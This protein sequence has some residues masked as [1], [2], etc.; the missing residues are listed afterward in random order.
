MSD[1]LK[2]AQ[3][4]C[5]PDPAENW[6]GLT[7]RE[8][9]DNLEKL[10]QGIQGQTKEYQRLRDI[11]VESDANKETLD[12]YVSDV[13]KVKRRLGLLHDTV[14]HVEN[15]LMPS[16][17]QARRMEEFGE[18][19]KK[20]NIEIDGQSH[21][22][23]AANRDEA[24]QMVRAKLA[25]I[26]T[27][28]EEH[29]EEES[30]KGGAGT[31]PKPRG[32][33]EAKLKSKIESAKAY[34]KAHGSAVP[35]KVGTVK[36][37]EKYV[38]IDQDGRETGVPT[39]I[40]RKHPEGHPQAGE[41]KSASQRRH[42]AVQQ[43]HGLLTN[44]GEMASE[45]AKLR[46]PSRKQ[47]EDAAE[48]REEKKSKSLAG[49]IQRSIGEADSPH[50][51]DH[52]ENRVLKNYGHTL[53][54]ARYRQAARMY[55]DAVG[56]PTA[57]GEG[58]TTAE[59]TVHQFY[60]KKL[61]ALRKKSPKEYSESS[62]PLIAE[63]DELLSQIRSRLDP[64]TLNRE[65]DRLI[66]EAAQDR[67]MRAGV[68]PKILAAAEKRAKEAGKGEIVKQTEKL[69]E[70]LPSEETPEEKHAPMVEAVDKHF[71]SLA[72]HKSFTPP[73][74]AMEGETPSEVL[75]REG[76]QA[77][78]TSD[79]QER[80]EIRPW[81]RKKYS[82]LL[83]GKASEADDV[84]EDTRSDAQ[85]A[86]SK[87]EVTEIATAR[88]PV[89]S[90]RSLTSPGA[91][92]EF[93]GDDA[94]EVLGDWRAWQADNP[95]ADPKEV[96]KARKRAVNSLVRQSSFGEHGSEDRRR[97][98]GRV[99]G[100]RHLSK[101]LPTLSEKEAEDVGKLD[102]PLLSESDIQS[103]VEDYG[104]KRERGKTDTE[105]ANLGVLKQWVRGLKSTLG[106]ARKKAYNAQDIPLGES[107][108][109]EGHTV[110]KDRYK[111]TEKKLL[112][113]IISRLH[114]G[115]SEKTEGG[116]RPVTELSSG[117]RKKLMSKVG[118]TLDDKKKLKS[119][120]GGD[121]PFSVLSENGKKE[122]EELV[123]KSFDWTYGMFTKDVFPGVF[124]SLNLFKNFNA[125]EKDKVRAFENS[126]GRDTSG[127]NPST[128]NSEIEG[129]EE[130]EDSETKKSLG[131]YLDLSK[132]KKRSKK[133]S[134]PDRL[135]LKT[136]PEGMLLKDIRKDAAEAAA[137]RKKDA[138]DEDAAYRAAPLDSPAREGSIVDRETKYAPKFSQV[139]G[140]RPA[141]KLEE[142]Q[143]K[144]ARNR[145][146]N[147]P[148]VEGEPNYEA[149][150]KREAPKVE[151][152]RPP[153]DANKQL[154]NTRFRR[155]PK[156][157]KRFNV[158]TKE[159]Q[160]AYAKKMGVDVSALSPKVREVLSGKYADFS[161]RPSRTPKVE[162]GAK[163]KAKL[164][165]AEKL[166][167]EGKIFTSRS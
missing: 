45:L 9:H 132:A 129:K 97:L 79:D 125:S 34:A 138:D 142:T 16:M 54:P 52:A 7:D 149:R 89:T 62:E 152:Y 82:S 123:R 122:I 41:L 69:R 161:G 84:A 37:Q 77:A 94:Q 144:A 47:R 113:D 78:A 72:G 66:M 167:K 98:I 154:L 164:A 53:T 22:Q 2:K 95:D 91:L 83:G 17:S 137:K 25:R 111:E 15:A 10:H 86:R 49:R 103:F 141:T 85:K 162:L 100:E 120:E 68:P 118:K 156:G 44:L 155:A 35:V 107:E 121:T 57:R 1:D 67:E 61:D 32:E 8:L 158:T 105:N 90:G 147:F 58:G 24:E 127:V 104:K 46:R 28:R 159:G 29:V 92:S 43:G 31:P 136:Y 93:M 115:V 33:R 11:I 160:D 124:L 18:P 74:E 101:L 153:T 145:D 119:G 151:G 133:R 21:R 70:D 128:M 30:G 56:N 60:Q 6:K 139:S 65:H 64:S 140:Y 26:K 126:F 13:S 108:L 99:R 38:I 135:S 114:Q 39:L 75:S 40:D 102:K 88:D 42:E 73:T 23:G 150:L 163:A 131:L 80:G 130:D 19:E 12:K 71:E 146:K 157:E 143:A 55:Y 3:E 4:G 116:D 50:Q 59:K 87:K 63:R 76:S 109:S 36:G 106:S 110:F 14:K 112:E 27:M 134:K 81:L 48:R 51:W 148:R 166:F 20:F 96:D 165:E 117:E 5:H